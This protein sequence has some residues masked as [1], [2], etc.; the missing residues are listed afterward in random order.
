[1]SIFDAVEVRSPHG[2]QEAGLLVGSPQE[3][4]LVAPSGAAA[5]AKAMTVTV[6]FFS[7]LRAITG[8]ESLEKSF[9]GSGEE[10][11][12]NDLLQELY[13]EFPGL[14]EWDTRLLIGVNLAYASKSTPLAEGQEIALMPPV[15]G[16]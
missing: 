7:S 5:Y 16:G 3:S 13:R 1:M 12:V 15:Q 2:T 14:A 6:L 4:I 11:T 10:L 8:R 9:P